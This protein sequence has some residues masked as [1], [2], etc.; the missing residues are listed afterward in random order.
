MLPVVVLLLALATPVPAAYGADT[1][2]LDASIGYGSGPNDFDAGFGFNF[3]GGYN[4]PSIDKNLQLRM[5]IGYFMFDRGVL[6][7]TLDYTRMPF[8]F[9][10]RYYLPVADRL[11]LFGQATAEISVDE[12]DVFDAFGKRSESEVNLGATPAVGVDFALSPQLSLFGT[13]SMH[14]ISDSYFSMQF[15]TAYHF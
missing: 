5:E 3:G 12:F 8:G 6:G 15:G 7:T 9:G 4:L 14:L 2:Q 1:M 13:A 10:A 11:K